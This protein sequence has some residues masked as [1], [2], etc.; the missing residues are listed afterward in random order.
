[1][2]VER[3]RRGVISGIDSSAFG[4]WCSAAPPGGMGWELGLKAVGRAIVMTTDR[5][6]SSCPIGPEHR[7]RATGAVR[8]PRELQDHSTIDQA[9]EKRGC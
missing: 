5:S 8:T 9:V 3:L 4:D 6:S 1:M 2:P 7:L